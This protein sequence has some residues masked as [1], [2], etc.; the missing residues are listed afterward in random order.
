M[1]ISPDCITKLQR[2]PIRVSRKESFA[3]AKKEVDSGIKPGT[4]AYRYGRLT[5]RADQEA[6]SRSTTRSPG[7]HEYTL[8]VEY[9]F[10]ALDFQAF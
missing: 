10:R 6:S 4:N 3:I 8:S 1:E 2:T 7:T 5:N 9:C